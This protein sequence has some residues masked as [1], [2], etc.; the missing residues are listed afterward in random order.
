V[1]FDEFTLNSEYNYF[2]DDAKSFNERVVRFQKHLKNQRGKKVYIVYYRPRILNY[3]DRWRGSQLADRA[4]WEIGYAS[5]IKHVDIEVVEGG[6]RDE[7]TIEFWV[8][9]RKSKPP[10]LTPTFQPSESIECPSVSVYLQNPAFDRSEPAVFIAS[11]Y[12]KSNLKAKW[13]VSSGSIVDGQGADF[14]KVD[15]KGSERITVIATVEGIQPPCNS[16]AIATAD[17]GP[18][19]HLL[20]EYGGLPES[21]IRGRLDLLMASVSNDSKVKGEI[22]IYGNRSSANSLS[23]SMRLVQNHF[24]FRRFPPGRIIVTPGGYREAGGM[25]LWLYPEGTKGPQPRPTVDEKFVRPPTR[26]KAGRNVR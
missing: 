5:P 12:P 4:K 17:I 6:I 25:E 11:A 18:R 10:T 26:R 24:R 14:L 7:G 2:F 9:S 20:D 23:V 19:P 22:I 1:K 13:S 21:D 15:P 16:S 3:S 8:G